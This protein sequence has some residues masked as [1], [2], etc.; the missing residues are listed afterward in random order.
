MTTTCPNWDRESWI[1]SDEYIAH[2]VKALSEC[3]KITSNSKILDI[4]CGRAGITI[5]LAEAS[6][7]TTPIEGIDISDTINEA[8]NCKKVNLLQIDAISYLKEQPDELYHGVILKRMLHCIKEELRKPLL[9]EV[10]RC[11]KKN[12]RALVFIMPPEITIPMFM[13]GKHTF[14]QEQLHF[15]DILNLG[16]DCL[17]ET[18]TTHFCFN[19]EIEKQRY[20]D[21]LRQRFMSNL[22]NFS[23]NEIENGVLEI[24]RDYPDDVLKFEDLMYIIHLIKKDSTSQSL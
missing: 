4:G 20:F 7:V 1:S 15:Q 3:L 22:R 10:H 9:Q 11:L 17:F 6:K 5:A 8:P 14:L 24:D 23:D 19:V 21:L 13:Q 16:Q 2:S 18:E 12:A